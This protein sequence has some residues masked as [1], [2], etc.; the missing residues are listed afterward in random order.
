M[1]AVISE[2]FKSIQ[3][4][5]PNIGAP[6][7]FVRFGGCNL[8]C[9]FCDTAYSSF[10][11]YAGNWISLEVSEII[12][13]IHEIRGSAYNLVLT[14]GEP[15]LQQKALKELIGKVQSFFPS[16]EVETNGTIL[17]MELFEMPNIFYNVSV[18][19]ANSG[20]KEEQRIVDEPLDFFSN[21]ERAYFKFVVEDEKDVKEVLRIVEKYYISPQ[22]VLLMPL[23]VNPVQLEDNANKVIELCLKY[24]FRYS[25]RLH[26]RLFGGKRGM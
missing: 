24:G 21:Y 17:P 2:I 13:K 18:K 26:F 14:G 25:D 10:P 15:L 5:G 16:I 11:E 20:V 8:R 22:R 7:V 19:L 1:K 3:G 12:R 9:T 4:E 6:S 23:S